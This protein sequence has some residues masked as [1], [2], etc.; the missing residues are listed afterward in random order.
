MGLRRAELDGQKRER[1]VVVILYDGLL[2]LLGG[3]EDYE[4]EEEM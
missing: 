1:V 3:L 4:G 2:L